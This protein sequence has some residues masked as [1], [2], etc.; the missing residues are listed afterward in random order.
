MEINYKS[1]LVAR[2]MGIS[3]GR[4]V[5]LGLLGLRTPSKSSGYKVE[6]ILTLDCRCLD[7]TD[8]DFRDPVVPVS[9]RISRTMDRQLN[10]T[11]SSKFGNA[12][13]L[14]LVAG[15]LFLPDER[16]SVQ[17]GLYYLQRDLFV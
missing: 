2:E 15:F 17:Y 13:I 10:A 11:T 12:P 14:G 3:S 8:G 1:G 9:I 16:I 6:I 7:L 5:P 4:S